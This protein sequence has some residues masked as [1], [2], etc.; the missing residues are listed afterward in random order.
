MNKK[1]EEKLKRFSE[2]QE[3]VIDP[4]II[5]NQKEYKK[6]AKEM[7]SLQKI[8]SK[9][10]E[11]QKIV[12]EITSL[13]AVLGDTEQE[14]E[15]LK[16]AEDELE[17]HKATRGKL[18]EELEE[19]LLEKDENADKDIIMEIRQGTGGVEAAL[20]AHDLFRMYSRYAARKGWKVE[21][22]SASVTEKG[23]FKEAIFSV[24]GDGVYGDFKYESGTHRVQR[25]PATETSGRIHTSAATVAVLPEAEDVDMEIKPQ[26]LRIDVFRAGGRGGQHVNVTDSA[27]RIT[28]MPTGLVV[29]CQDERSQYKN[30]AKAMRVL[31]ARLFDK[32][33]QDQ[34]KKRSRD[35]KLQVGSGDRSEKIRTYNFPDRRVT[36]HRI[37]FT[38]H[39]LEGV[40]NGALDEF[41]AAL[42]EADRKERM[43]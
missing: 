16:L 28:H 39:N 37:G 8:V 19:L 15:F 40:L 10:N 13:E 14:K 12:D 42:R 6:Y 1:L 2:L 29:S 3:L 21:T 22:I 30:K 35:R 27:V 7:S 17:S 33:T 34:N 31:R 9:Y 23:G 41:I 4:K 43:K 5:S 11:Y 18:Q 38:K 32:I 36:D 24:S 26:D 25:V 20:F